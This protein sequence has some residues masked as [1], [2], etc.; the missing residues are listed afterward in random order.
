MMIS[1]NFNDDHIILFYIIYNVYS[2]SMQYY[3]SI[4]YDK[5]NIIVDIE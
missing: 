1:Y 4:T 2:I 5:N 3:T